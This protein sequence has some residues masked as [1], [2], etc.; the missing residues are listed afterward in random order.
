ML[1]TAAFA[2]V[3]GAA[4]AMDLD[5]TTI[6]DVVDPRILLI[7]N[8]SNFNNTNLQFLLAGVALASLAG[9]LM[10]LC[11]YALSYFLGGDDTGYSGYGG[12]Y[13]RYDTEPDSYAAY[14]QGSQAFQARSL[15]GGESS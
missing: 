13:D 11:L 8:G 14:T 5:T 4:S 6:E 10:A 3:L 9:L 2:T 1:A 12:G 15:G 7:I